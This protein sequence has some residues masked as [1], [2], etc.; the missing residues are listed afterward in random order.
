M[1]SWVTVTSGNG[2]TGSGSVTLQVA[3][4]PLVYPRAAAIYIGGELVVISQSNV[5]AT[6]PGTP[7]RLR[8]V[9]NP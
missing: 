3:A 6:P 8:V 5:T 7:G 1:L 2:G 4:N 9:P